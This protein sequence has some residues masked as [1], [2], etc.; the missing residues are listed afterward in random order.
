MN[1]TGRGPNP[2]TDREPVLEMREIQGLVVPGLLKPHQ[3]L[4]GVRI[5][6]GSR[7]VELNFKKLLCRLVEEEIV[8]TAK[9][10]LENRK[11]YRQV[12]ARRRINA[13]PKIHR[14]LCS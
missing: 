8:T 7:E 2:P 9:E 6:G 5:P 11:E 13:I 4:L 10:T 14:A 3:T 1:D 12:R